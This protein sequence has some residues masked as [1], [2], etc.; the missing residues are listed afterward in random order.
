VGGWRRNRKPSALAVAA[1]D[2]TAVG[3]KSYSDSL[4][5]TEAVAGL[6]SRSISVSISEAEG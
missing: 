6:Y 4:T 3:F 2:A 1:A 5:I